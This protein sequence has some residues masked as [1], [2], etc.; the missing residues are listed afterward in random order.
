MIIQFFFLYQCVNPGR[1]VLPP[2]FSR[3]AWK[4]CYWRTRIQITPKWSTKLAANATFK[5]TC[6]HIASRLW[7]LIIICLIYLYLVSCNIFFLLF[8]LSF[9][10]RPLVLRVSLFLP[11]FFFFSSS[12]LCA[13]G[14]RT[15]GKMDLDSWRW[16]SAIDTFA[17]RLCSFVI[18]FGCFILPSPALPSVLLPNGKKTNK[19]SSLLFWF[20]V[21]IFV[22]RES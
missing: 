13:R 17:T 7:N 3:L 2:L 9:W 20:R 10:Q 8:F 19:Q 5:I 21:Y 15:K 6:T 4:S 22:E 11:L 18:S 14:K 12:L 16:N 1:N